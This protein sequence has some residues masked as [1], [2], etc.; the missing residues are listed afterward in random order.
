MNLDE[1]WQVAWTSPGRCASPADLDGAGLDWTPAQVPGT[2]AGAVGSDGRDFDAQ[3]WWFR[4]RFAARDPAE[5][6]L[7]LD[8]VATVSEVYLNGELVLESDSMFASHRLDVGDRLGARERAGDRVPGAHS[9]VGQAPAPERPLADARGQRRQ[10]A[11][12][13]DDDVRA[14]ARIRARSCAGGSVAAGVVGGARPAGLAAGPRARRGKRWDRDR[15]R[16][17]RPTPRMAMGCASETP[18]PRCATRPSW[19]CRAPRCGGPTPTA[20]PRCTRSRSSAATRRSPRRRI[21]FRA[22][23]WAEDIARDGLDLQ[24]NGVPCGCAARCGP[25]PTWCPWPPAGP[26]ARPARARPRSRNEHG[27]RRRHRRL[28][29]T[30]L[31][32]SLRRAGH[33][34]L[35]GPHVRQPRLPGLAIRSSARACWARRGRAGRDGRPRQPR[36]R[37]RQQ[38][39]RAAAGH[40]GPRPRTGA[41]RAV[42]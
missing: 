15:H 27:A 17:G 42:G 5:T 37:L 22:L 21:G 13:S 12:V 39:G 24:V 3:D 16:S 40:D 10:P 33:P 38:R 14:L 34:R 32:R 18:T 30:G 25:Q 23:G 2:A 19:W 31:L 6:E 4:A 20:T 9:A 8:G 7:R 35:A 11:L 29:D 28:R 36:R 26:V 1:G 41:R